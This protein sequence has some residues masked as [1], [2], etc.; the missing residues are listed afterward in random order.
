MRFLLPVLLFSIS[1]LQA[2]D[3][4][5]LA[6]F[7]KKWTNATAYTLEI[8]ELMPEEHYDFKPTAEVRSFREQLMHTMQN[9]IWLSSTYLGDQKFDGDL[10]NME[11]SKAEVIELYKKASRQNDTRYQ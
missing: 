5:I 1:F 10:K 6:D 9:V 2:Q 8:A 4:S 3:E 7:S 11:L